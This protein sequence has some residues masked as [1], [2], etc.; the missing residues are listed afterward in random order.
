[1]QRFQIAPRLTSQVRHRTTYLDMPIAEPQAFVF[2]QNGRP[3]PR[4]GSLKEFVDL[5]AL[6]ADRARDLADDISQAVR[7]RYEMAPLRSAG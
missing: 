2:T 4:A 7:A 6:G 5:L 1:M 3:G